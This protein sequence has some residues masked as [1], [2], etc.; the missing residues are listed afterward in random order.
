MTEAKGKATMI[1]HLDMKC[2]SRDGDARRLVHGH[3]YS[4]P[5]EQLRGCTEFE[6]RAGR[7][8][9]LVSASTGLARRGRAAGTPPGTLLTA[10][11]DSDLTN[12]RA[13]LCRFIC[14]TSQRL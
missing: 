10:C 1:A 14:A 2:G 7:P 4:L 6:K 12:A 8:I 9:G 11:R 5:G 3:G 13:S